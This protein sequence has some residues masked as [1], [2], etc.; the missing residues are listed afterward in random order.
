MDNLTGRGGGK[1]A[2]QTPI[3]NEHIGITLA[4]LFSAPAAREFRCHLL[5]RICPNPIP[6]YPNF[7]YYEAKFPGGGGGVRDR[8]LRRSED[9]RL[10]ASETPTYIIPCRHPRQACEAKEATGRPCSLLLG[11]DSSSGRKRTRGGQQARRAEST[12]GT[13]EGASVF[14]NAGPCPRRVHQ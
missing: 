4:I 6:T 3:N 14:E 10:L 12:Y 9:Y 7:F 2:E 13:I 8:R 1:K 5:C 11:G